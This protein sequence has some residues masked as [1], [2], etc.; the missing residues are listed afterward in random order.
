MLLLSVGKKTDCLPS[1]L[2]REVRFIYFAAGVADVLK[3]MF[4]LMSIPGLSGNLD[5]SLKIFD[6]WNWTDDL[7]LNFTR[8]LAPSIDDSI[9][10]VSRHNCDVMFS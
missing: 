2:L 8:Y 9:R 5:Q 3:R 1:K 10:A 6:K 4:P 7:I